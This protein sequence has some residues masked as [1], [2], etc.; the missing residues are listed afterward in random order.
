[1]SGSEAG[2]AVKRFRAAAGAVSPAVL[3][4][5]AGLFVY[6]FRDLRELFLPADFVQIA[7]ITLTVL[8]VHLIKAGRLFLAVYGSE[9]NIWPY[10]EVYCRVTPVSVILPYKLGEFFRMYGYGREFGSF[11]KGIVTI[12]LDRFMDTMALITVILVTWAFYG[13]RISGF[14]YALLLFLACVLLLYFAFP[15]VYRYWKKFLLK[16]RASERRLALLRMIELSNSLYR[17]MAAVSRGRGIILYFLSLIAWTV[18]IGSLALLGGLT[19]RGELSETV[20]GYLSAA[21]GTGTSPE[22]KRFIFIS[23]I[24]LAAILG[25]LRIRAWMAGKRGRH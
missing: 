17:E 12:V 10:C 21:M 20:S 19:G 6:E 9:M 16:S 23:V 14:V 2:K 4:L 7:V 3:L 24:L 18:E 22:L 13:G 5:S 15:G 1:M 11:L 25:G 8:I